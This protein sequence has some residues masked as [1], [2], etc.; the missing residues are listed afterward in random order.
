MVATVY[1]LDPGSTIFTSEEPDPNYQHL[2]V[3]I[4]VQNCSDVVAGSGG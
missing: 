4:A 1:L 3:V 2:V